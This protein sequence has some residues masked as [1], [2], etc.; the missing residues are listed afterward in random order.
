MAMDEQQL[1]YWSPASDR[2]IS[3]LLH[4][5]ISTL[6]RQKLGWQSGLLDHYKIKRGEIKLNREKKQN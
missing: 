5:I 1:W 2:L 4:L 6:G 3:Q